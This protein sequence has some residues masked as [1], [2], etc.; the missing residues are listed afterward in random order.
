MSLKEL[1]EKKLKLIADAR[2]IQDKADKEKRSMT[3]EER[4]SA[5]KMLDD[6]TAVDKEIEALEGEERTRSRIKELET[7]AGRG[8]E[9]RSAPGQP[10]GSGDAG[11]D[12]SRSSQEIMDEYRAAYD[13]YLRYGLGE[14]T[15]EERS[16]LRSRAVQLP[17]EVRALLPGGAGRPGRREQ[18][19]QAVGT[20]AA[21]GFTVAP[22]FQ[23]E[24]S[25]AMLAYQGIRQAGA[26]HFTGDSGADLPFGSNDDTAVEATIV[27][28]AAAAGA[29]TDL[30]FAQK[31][32]KTYMYTTGMLKVSMQLLQ[33]NAVNIEAYIR[34]A[35]AERLGRGTNTHWTT[36]NGTTQ[37]E[38]IITALNAGSGIGVTTASATLITADE[39][40]SL[41]HS[42]DPAYRDDPTARYAFSDGILKVIRL[43]K[44][45][46]GRYLLTEPTQAAP[47]SLWGKPW[48][49]FSKMAAAPTTGA[50]TAVF[51]A[52]RHYK[53]R[54]VLGL[55]IYRADQ[56]FIANGQVGFIGF[57]RFGGGF[58]N[59]GNFPIKCM[60]QA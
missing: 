15:D 53:T 31:V 44:D 45:T 35:F 36:G 7:A 4:A 3:A 6:V 21:G 13:S 56:L 38:G 5:D 58:V 34:D 20:G 33:D 46:S 14:C 23:A 30:T 40:L 25:K 60:K 43:L 18:R 17:D 54:E 16:I 37:P 29:A 51:G 9:R 22:L 57:A 59:T 24:I 48:Q 2:A 55:A 42:V 39:L 26:Q 11:L 1:R 41:Q 8:G 50:V 47:G 27:G 10:G 28:E 19:D 49:I 52:M 12:R 32:I